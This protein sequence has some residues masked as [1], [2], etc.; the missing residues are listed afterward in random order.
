MYE[1]R[2]RSSAYTSCCT[3][4]ASSWTT[5]SRI[6]IDR[7]EVVTS[8]SEGA[9][10]LDRVDQRSMSMRAMSRRPTRPDVSAYMATDASM[11]VRNT[12]IIAQNVTNC[13]SIT[14]LLSRA[15]IGGNNP[16]SGH[17]SPGID[18]FRF[19]TLEC[20]VGQSMTFPPISK[21][22]R[23]RCSFSARE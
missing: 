2:E 15:T 13:A 22:Q 20:V 5:P 21:S 23:C 9:K 10:L 1:Q 6:D 17:R 19:G 7:H 11:P 18:S 4:L 16:K 3:L 14:S 12:H 8:R